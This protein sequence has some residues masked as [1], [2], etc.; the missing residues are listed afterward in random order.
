MDT[1][2]FNAVFNGD[3]AS[4]VFYRC[5]VCKVDMD[6]ERIK[7]HH[8]IEKC[9][10]RSCDTLIE[11]GEM[12]VT[13][14][15]CPH[16]S[17]AVDTT[18]CQAC[19]FLHLVIGEVF[20]CF[21]C[22]K[23]GCGENIRKCGFISD[24]GVSC[25]KHICF[26]C[27][28]KCDDLCDLVRCSVDHAVRCQEC[29]CTGPV[30]CEYCQSQYDDRGPICIDCINEFSPE[31]I[32][33]KDEKERVAALE[34]KKELDWFWRTWKMSTKGEEYLR[35]MPISEKQEE[36]LEREETV[37]S[38]GARPPAPKKTVRF[39]GWNGAWFAPPIHSDEI[40]DD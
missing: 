21:K 24:D 27:G 17:A 26:D 19:S 35:R 25:D 28:E 33:A 9:L 36:D 22:Q 2:S 8:P 16:C 13:N 23:K 15:T 10:C 39:W 1:H 34:E 37:H 14:L 38:V 18:L 20:E 11:E 12:C 5:N 4:S 32:R 30:R 3:G 31:K 6:W 7:Y 40:A 29:G